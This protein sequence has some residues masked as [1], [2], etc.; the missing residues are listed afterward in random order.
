MIKHNRHCVFQHTF[1][2]EYNNSFS[3]SNVSNICKV[4]Q[5][6]SNVDNEWFEVENYDY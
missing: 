6:Y 5:N 3:L 1:Y 2:A 4:I